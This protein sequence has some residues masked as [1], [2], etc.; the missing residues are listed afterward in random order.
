[1]ITKQWYC[2]WYW[3]PYILSQT[4]KCKTCQTLL[5]CKYSDK[6][7]FFPTPIAGSLWPLVLPDQQAKSYKPSQANRAVRILWDLPE[8]GYFPEPS[9]LWAHRPPPRDNI[10]SSGQPFIHLPED[11]KFD[12]TTKEKVP[13]I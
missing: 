1:M 12:F 11:K 2:K 6:D 5:V 9:K 8:L 4:F 3:K 10:L 13:S 7:G